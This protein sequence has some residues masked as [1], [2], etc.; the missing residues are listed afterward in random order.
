MQ[1]IELNKDL[2]ISLNNYTEK[3]FVH[4]KFFA[5]ELLPNDPPSYLRAKWYE[6]YNK[7]IS[8]SERVF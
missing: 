4:D 7:I 3:F 5:T 6:T 1:L 8:K 2:D